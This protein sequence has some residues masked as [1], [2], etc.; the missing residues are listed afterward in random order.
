MVMLA[1]IMDDSEEQRKLL[2]KLRSVE[3]WLEFPER[4]PPTDSEYHSFW[5][6]A[7]R[8]RDEKERQAEERAARI[9][10]AKER[11]T[12][13]DKLANEICERISSGELLTVICNDPHLPTAR[14]AILWLKQHS[15]FNALYQLALMDRLSIFEDQNIE[16]ADKLSEK[17]Q[18]A[19]ASSSKE[20]IQFRDPVQKAKLQIEVRMKHLRALRPQRWAD[21]STLNVKNDDAFDFSNLSSEEIER[22]IAEIENKER[23]VKGTRKD[24]FA[25]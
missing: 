10:A 7:Q 3:Y 2:A 8:K 22:R 9:K 19:I 18:R 15:D 12:Y 20:K 21:T 14:N 24:M 1:T 5:V 25:A 17:P 13:S 11:V 23:I 6:M 16:F 4:K